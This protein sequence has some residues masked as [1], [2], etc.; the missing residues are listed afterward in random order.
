MKI[1]RTSVL[2]AVTAAA[3]STASFAA[4]TMSTGTAMSPSEGAYVA[5]GGGINFIDPRQLSINGNS[6][7]AKF[8]DG[9]ALSGAGGYKWEQGFRSEL[10]ISYRENKVKNFRSNALPWTGTQRDTSAMANLLFDINTGSNWTPYVGGGIGI[11]W[12]NWDQFK[13]PG[14]TV[15]D[16]TSSKFAWQGIVGVA[17]NVAHNLDLTLD[18]R[19]KGSNGNAYAGNA[20]GALINNYNARATSVMVG[21]RYAFGGPA[22]KPMAPAP[23]AA[24]KPAAAAPMAQAPMPARPAAPPVPQKFLV[25]FDFDKSNLRA[26]AKKIVAEAAEYAKK[27]GKTSIAATGHADTSGTNAYNLALSERRA[28]AVKDELVR[29]GIPEREIVVRWK[30]ESE[31]LVQTGDGV[32]EPQNRRV[33]IVLE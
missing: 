2:A 9:F 1:L 16:G 26:D 18:A 13:G 32:K 30:G 17:V 31:P 3:L 4:E 29:I 10:E 5:V 25:F 6:V 15:Y 11:S 23:A 19:Y 22:A 28:K 33:E 14:P 27:N 7:K 20:A 12:L 24:P 21:F 8:K